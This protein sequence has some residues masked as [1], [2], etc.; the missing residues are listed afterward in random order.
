MA[1]PHRA[2]IVL[3]GGYSTRFGTQEKALA[4]LDGKPLLAH[5]VTGIAP[6]VDG[7]L[8]NCRQEQVPRF[9]DALA[10]VSADVAFVCDPEPDRGPAAGLATACDAVDAP[11]IAVV[12]CD[13]PFVD[14]AF[15]DWLFGERDDADGVV[16]CVDGTPQPTHAVFATKPTRRATD[17]VVRNAS[18]SLRDVLER[19][20]IVEIPES[21]VV[22]KTAKTSFVDIN[23]P[24]DLEN[25]SG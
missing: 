5:A 25:R 3:A 13:M 10:S 14:A 23:T 19:L 12:A 20:D 7:V 2:G 9:R 15:L 8:V 1:T 24:E 21:C 11:H 17:D 6:A 4:N 16:P 18:G 22:E